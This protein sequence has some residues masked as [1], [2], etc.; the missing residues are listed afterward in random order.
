MSKSLQQIPLC[1][2]E[3]R[4]F[5]RTILRT[6]IKYVPVAY[7]PSAMIIGLRLRQLRESKGLS[8][9]DIERR[10]GLLRCYTSRVEHGAT[11][12]SVETLQKYAYA[13]EVPLYRFFYDGDA[14]PEAPKLP[15]A[16]QA[17]TNDKEPREFRAFAKA[18]RQLCDRDRRLLLAMAVQMA[19]K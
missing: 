9:G 6:I 18:I 16:L 4:A 19:R 2:P 5:A 17:P 10:T 14:P 13:I 7:N 15:A 3:A 11:V 12:P 8:Q 1:T